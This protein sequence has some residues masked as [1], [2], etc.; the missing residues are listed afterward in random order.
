[1]RALSIVVLSALVAVACGFFV[2][3]THGK[4]KVVDKETLVKQKAIFEVLHH[5]FQKDHYDE[6]YNV[7]QSYTFEGN[8]DHYTNAT[9]V[10]EFVHLYKHGLLPKGAV[11][12]VYNTVHRQEVVALFNVFYYAKDFET[13]YK[14]MVWARDHV[15][16]EQ[17][18]YALTAAV[19]HRHDLQGIELPAPYEIY[20][21]H[22]VNYEVITKAY[23]HKMEKT[24][25]NVVIPANYSGWY[26]QTSEEQELTYFTEDVG[27]NSFYYY[28]HMD[29]PFWMGGEHFTLN[30]DR[31]G[32]LYFFTIQ[33]LLARYYL[34]RVSHQFGEIPEL[35]HDYVSETS[36]YPTMHHFNGLDFPV[37]HE[38]H[39]YNYSEYYHEYVQHAH[40]YERRI[41]DVIDYGFVVLPD[42]SHFDLTKPEAINVL[43]NLI[44]SNPDSYNTRFYKSFIGVLKVILGNSFDTVDYYHQ[45]PSAL[46]CFNTAMR[47]PAFYQMYKKVV[48]YYY[49]FKSH[50]PSYT[51]EELDFQGVKIEGVEFDKLVTY[52]DK[53]VY[54]ISNALVYSEE[55]FANKEVYHPVKVSQER[56]NHKPF[57]YK[58]NVVSDKETDAVVRVFIGPKY[59]EH[60]N[61][62]SFEENR[63]NFFQVDVFKYH[64]KS[65][66][67][68]VERKSEDYTFFVKDRTSHYTLYKQVMGALSG[69]GE[70]HF[71][72]TE[73]HCGFPE[74]LMIPRGT[75]GG[76][77]YQFFFVVSPYHA[78]ATTQYQGFDPVVSCGV[79]S[80][81][82]YVD[83]LPLGYPFDRELDVTVFPTP[84]MYYKDVT[85]YHKETY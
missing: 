47:D 30:K 5:V 78:P 85:I 39:I 18:V 14:T 44:N 13:F 41:R 62:F 51:H 59:D 34:E 8:Y 7:G 68:V 63:E 61:E 31:R 12:N 65:G 81:A 50:L 77:E 28:F 74:R 52:F 2:P 38:G 16:A 57:T 73:A 83:S 17:F 84:N 37:R 26:V 56:L 76:I 9:A 75:K 79:G 80:G 35:S 64:L 29:Y 40:D 22:F 58:M 70:F 48:K 10:K 49:Q 24:H 21:H 11:F 6:H 15:N 33:Q 36:Y 1:M 43:G 25:T 19:F 54:D 32:E 42:G 55:E 69:Q 20:P 60:H 45:Y 67:N 3:T 46:E 4:Y 53:Y 23:Q 82:R 66:K 72:N 71:D 27:L